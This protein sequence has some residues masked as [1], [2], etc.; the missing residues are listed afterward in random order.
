MM[1][2][3]LMRVAVQDRFGAET[4]D[5]GLERAGVGQAAQRPSRRAK[6]GDDGSG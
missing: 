1:N 3:A 2:H 4:R 6:A 5:D